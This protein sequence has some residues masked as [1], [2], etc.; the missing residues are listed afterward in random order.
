M[1]PTPNHCFLC[2]YEPITSQRDPDKLVFWVA[3]PVCLRYGIGDLARDLIIGEMPAERRAMLAAAARRNA[4][5]NTPVV[6]TQDTI[7]EIADSVRPPGTPADAMQ[8]ILTYVGNRQRTFAD[9]VE[10]DTRL[11][12]A[13]RLRSADE[14]DMVLQLLVEQD[15]ISRGTTLEEEGYQL[16]RDGWEAYRKSHAQGRGSKRAFVAMWFDD[17][18]QPVWGDAIKPAIIDAGYE[19]TRVDEI[20][21]NER[22]DD[23]IIAEIRKARFVVA[24]FTGQRGGVYFEAGFGRGLGLPVIWTCRRDEVDDIHFDTRQ[25]NFILWETTD[26]LRKSLRARIEAT[27]GPPES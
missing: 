17:G 23:T 19:P 24:D 12:P 15:L 4:E 21:H 1:T 11:F 27:M 3:C 10:V 5:Q 13:F 22:I 7:D 26:E 25:Y 9:R 14:L 6:I 20:P 16:T 8:E 18:M 2:G